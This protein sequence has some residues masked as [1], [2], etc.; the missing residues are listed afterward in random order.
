MSARVSAVAFY[1]LKLISKTNEVDQ[2]K[3]KKN[4][5]S[6]HSMRKEAAVLHFTQRIR[7]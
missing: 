1:I 3:K 6:T 5:L 4:L 7:I 2:K